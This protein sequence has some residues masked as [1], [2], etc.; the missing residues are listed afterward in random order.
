[1]T[2]NSEV[3]DLIQAFREGSISLDELALRFRQRT[4]PSA[5][6]PEPRTY[7]ELAEATERDPEPDVPGTFDE[8]IGAY[9]RG[10]IT[11]SQYRVLAEAV[12]ESKRDKHQDGV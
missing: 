9:D 5:K 1:M 2:M 8:V 12:A 6:A 11:Y 7:L 4:W 10:E 3:T